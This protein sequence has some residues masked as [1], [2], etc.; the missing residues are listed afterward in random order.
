MNS[1]EKPEIPEGAV[2]HVA[3]P[4]YRTKVSLL[5][6]D[7]PYETMSWRPG[8]YYE[9]TSPYGDG[10]A[11][12]DGLGKQVLT[13]ITKHKPGKYPERVFFTQSWIDPNGKSF[14]KTKLRMTTLAVFRR[15]VRGFGIEYEMR[16]KAA[17]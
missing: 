11:F 14:G 12:A 8:I 5:D 2:F 4:F 16:T 17:A 7:G 6:E 3:Y 13:V 15:R 1:Q 9:Q 10:Q